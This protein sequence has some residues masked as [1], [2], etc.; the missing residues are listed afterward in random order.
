MF[1]KETVLYLI[2]LPH[3]PFRVQSKERKK[4]LSSHIGAAPLFC[5]LYCRRMLLPQLR[6]EPG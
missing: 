6:K 3:K 1:A 5:Q 4:K 2:P